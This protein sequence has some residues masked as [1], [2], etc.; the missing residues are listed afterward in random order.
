M[1]QVSELSLSPRWRA[2]PSRLAASCL[3]PTTD[4]MGARWWAGSCVASLVL[5]F[6]TAY[7]PVRV[8]PL[9]CLAVAAPVIAMLAAGRSTGRASLPSAGSLFVALYVIFTHVGA[10]LLYLAD[11]FSNSNF[12][13]MSCVTLLAFAVGIYAPLVIVGGQ[14]VRRMARRLP[15]TRNDL[16][17]ERLVLWS[18]FAGLGAVGALVFLVGGAARTGKLPVV[19]L[20]AGGFSGDVR[21]FADARLAFASSAGQGYLYNLH[22]IVLP[23]SALA[24]L[25]GYLGTRRR[26]YLWPAALLSILAALA[27]LAG[28]YRGAVMLLALTA[29]VALA[30]YRGT[31]WSPATRRLGVAALALLAVISAAAHSDKSGKVS[32]REILLTRVFKIQALGPQYVYQTFPPSGDFSGGRAL[33]EDVKGV[34]PGTQRGLSSQLPEARGV[35]S[36]NNPVGVPAELYLNFGP[37]G[38]AAAMV[39]FGAACHCLHGWI[40]ERRGAGSVA[41]AAVL[42]TGVA[43]GA[44]AGIVGALFQFGVVTAGLMAV[45]THIVPRGR[46]RVATASRRRVGEEEILREEGVQ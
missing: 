9:L 39:L 2:A 14:R 44:L 7:L 36:L 25:F 5:G 24:F 13:A 32:T 17:G 30:Y 35:K 41:V 12:L 33:L 11:P 10:V 37:Y 40:V 31:A 15:L 27:S 28:G 46:S 1:W 26:R 19:S 20:A 29:C 3:G 43:Y 18:A 22:A 42:T 4:A 16:V 34:L 8:D 38:L 23:A 21:S 6:A 45:T